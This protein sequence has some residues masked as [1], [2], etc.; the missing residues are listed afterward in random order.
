[1]WFA[2]KGKIGAGTEMDFFAF[3][4]YMNMPMVNKPFDQV[5]AVKALV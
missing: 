5:V 3:P 1:M 2:F 4:R